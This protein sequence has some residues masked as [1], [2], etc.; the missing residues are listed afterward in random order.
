M[1]KDSEATPHPRPLF[2]QAETNLTKSH[3]LAAL[4]DMLLP[5][6]LSGKIQPTSK[7]L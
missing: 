5:K 2:Q 4:R 7:P 3:T 6:L 1:N